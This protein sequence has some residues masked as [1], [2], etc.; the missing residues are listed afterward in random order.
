LRIRFDAMDPVSSSLPRKSQNCRA[1]HSYPKAQL[2][3]QSNSM[4]KQEGT[5]GDGL[6]CINT[7]GEEGGR[8]RA[9]E[10]G[11]GGGRS[12]WVL[13]ASRRTRTHGL[14]WSLDRKGRRNQ[15]KARAPLPLNI[16]RPFK[17][18]RS[19]LAAWLPLLGCAYA[20]D[21]VQLQVGSIFVLDAL[22]RLMAVHG[23]IRLISIL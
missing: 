22:G 23:I 8:C 13:E 11:I 17:I 19:C 15:D 5:S 16:H 2:R 10:D 7:D 9:G 4:E 14:V 12:W 6:G 21:F 3:T 20:D 18:R 1:H